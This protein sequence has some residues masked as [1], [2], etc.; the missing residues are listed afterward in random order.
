MKEEI[1]DMLKK[2]YSSRPEFI[3]YFDPD[4]DIQ[5]KTEYYNGDPWSIRKGFFEK[6]KVKLI[7]NLTLHYNFLLVIRIFLI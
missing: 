6:G 4:L 1:Y 5:I 7:N 3:Y 2:E